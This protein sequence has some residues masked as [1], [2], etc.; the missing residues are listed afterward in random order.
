MSRLFPLAVWLLA[1]C[2]RPLLEATATVCQHLPAQRFTLPAGIVQPYAQLPPELR[3][4]VS[5]EHTFDFDV[6]AQLPPAVKE[7]TQSHVMLTSVR[8]TAVEPGA[9]LG[10]ID[11]GRLQLQPGAASGL[12]GRVFDYARVEDAPR[13]VSWNG[14]AFDVAAYVEAGHLKYTVIVMISSPPPGE[15]RVDLDACAEVSV[16]LDSL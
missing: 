3:R 15:V 16:K 4:G 12:E 13:I 10:F 8:L 2:G 1:G 14:E 9:D 5:L 11:E 6:S 7:L